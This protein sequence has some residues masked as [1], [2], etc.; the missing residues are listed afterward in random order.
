MSGFDFLAI[1]EKYSSVDAIE[2]QYFHQML[3]N[4]TIIFNS[5]YEEITLTHKV[6]DKLAYAKGVKE[7]LDDLLNKI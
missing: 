6:K 4:R 1:P 5:E 7:C 3:E 2:Y